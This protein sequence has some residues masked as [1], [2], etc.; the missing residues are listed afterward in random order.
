MCVHSNFNFKIQDFI[1]YFAYFRYFPGF[2]QHIPGC[3]ETNETAVGKFIEVTKKLKKTVAHHG[4]AMKN[5]LKI[6][7]S[8]TMF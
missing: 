6:C 4:W 5:I 2:F 8:G 1:E 7:L 3:F